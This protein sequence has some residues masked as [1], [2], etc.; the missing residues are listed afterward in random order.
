MNVFSDSDN[1]NSL[2]ISRLFSATLGGIDG[3]DWPG[4]SD[5]RE[6]R[7]IVEAS[8]GTKLGVESLMSPSVLG[9]TGQDGVLEDLGGSARDERQETLGP[10][11]ST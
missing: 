7:Y 4:T 1:I 2:V 6:G 3:V 11:L 5:Q 10:H 9:D 8:A